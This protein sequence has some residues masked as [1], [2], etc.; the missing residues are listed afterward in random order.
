MPAPARIQRGLLRASHSFW[1]LAAVYGGRIALQLNGLVSSF[2][3]KQYS[4]ALG[5][6]LHYLWAGW[7][8]SHAE[9]PY[10]GAFNTGPLC[11][12]YAAFLVAGILHI[13]LLVNH[14]SLPMH[15]QVDV[16][17]DEWIRWQVQ[18]T[19]DVTVPTYMDWFH[20]GLQFQIAHHLF[21]RLPAQYLREASKEVY[22][23]LDPKEFR[24]LKH[25]KFQLGLNNLFVFE[26]KANN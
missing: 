7:V 18:T 17:Q 3:Q 10:W 9:G 24:L 5:L 16:G 19:C 6:G 22:Q 1:Y 2:K 23:L 26:S 8:I 15:S 4:Q 13:Q 12:G 25:K 21:P 11:A 20:G 14:A